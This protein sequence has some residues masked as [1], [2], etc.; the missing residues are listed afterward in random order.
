MTTGTLK[1]TIMQL[2]PQQNQHSKDDGSGN[3][4][5]WRRARRRRR[6]KSKV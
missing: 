1:R 5:R 3:D 4:P 2:D 6:M